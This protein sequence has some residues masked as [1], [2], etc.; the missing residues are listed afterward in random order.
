MLRAGIIFLS[1]YKAMATYD[2]IRDVPG[3]GDF[4][5]MPPMTK[6]EYDEM[7]NACYDEEFECMIAQERDQHHDNNPWLDMDWV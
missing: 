4:D 3:L 1:N 5:D 7:M 6:A 2:D